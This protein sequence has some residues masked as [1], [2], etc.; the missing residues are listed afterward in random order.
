MDK[1]PKLIDAVEATIDNFFKWYTN[2]DNDSLI[3]WFADWQTSNCL[4]INGI[5]AQDDNKNGM[6][7]LKKLFENKEQTVTFNT[8]QGDSYIDTHFTI[9]KDIYTIQV[10]DIPFTEET[11]PPITFL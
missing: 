10:C 6:T 8:Y 4:T 1:S 3:K 2:E 9:N 7:I 5:H 11:Y